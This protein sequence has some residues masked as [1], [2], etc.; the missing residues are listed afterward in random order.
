MPRR[1]SGWTE[2]GMRRARALWTPQ[3]Q[4]RLRRDTERTLAR[5]GRFGVKVA[6]AVAPVRTGQLRENI[7]ATS[8]REGRTSQV[9]VGLSAATREEAIAAYVAEFGRGHGPRGEF[10]RG[11][12]AGRGFLR[13]SR[14]LVRRRAR[15]AIQRVMRAHARRELT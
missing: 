6:R 15:G 8:E 11:P 2:N 13:T 10:A 5:L 7:V 9:T 12:L 1:Q 4:A 14:I 3:S